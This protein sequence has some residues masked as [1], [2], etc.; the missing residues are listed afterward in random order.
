MGQAGTDAP[1]AALP[2][3]GGAIVAV[4][5]FV[6]MAATLPLASRLGTRAMLLMAEAALVIPALAA[7]AISRLPMVPALALK[8]ASRGTVFLS[9]AAG[10]AFWLASL[11]LL[12]LQS[13][14]WPPEPGYLEAFRRLHEQL[15]P[16]GAADFV[17][18]LAAIAVVPALCEEIMLRGVVLPSLKPALGAMGAVGASSLMFAL[19]HDPYRMPFTFVVGMGLGVLRVRTGA[20]TS[21]ALAHASL[22]TIT[23]L[24][25]WVFD[26]SLQDMSDPRPALGAALLLAGLALS[27]L[28]LRASGRAPAS[29]PSPAPR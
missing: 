9:M 18:S 4:L 25:A 8:P 1:R 11:G 5:G 17:V 10:A 23:F 24:A 29:G 3:W 15:R 27:L 14:F 12:E 20:L 2:A 21:S 28:F 16:R 19:Y 13:Y 22:N 26:D 6:A 7:L